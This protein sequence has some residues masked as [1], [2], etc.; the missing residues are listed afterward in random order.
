MTVSI[1][2]NHTWIN[3]REW[4]N[5]CWLHL[6]LPS[7]SIQSSLTSCRSRIVF[8]EVVEIESVLSIFDSWFEIMAKNLS[9]FQK[10][11][12]ISES[13]SVPILHSLNSL[14]ISEI[15]VG[16]R[17]FW[18]I[19]EILSAFQKSLWTPENLGVLQK[20]WCI[21][22]IFVVFQKFLMNLRNSKLCSMGLSSSPF[23]TT[24]ISWLLI[25]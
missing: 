4:T 19:L 18:R 13:L 25:Q 6:W 3:F 8:K 10:Y 22:K 23:F 7:Q 14:C 9:A 20:F 12:W 16:Y 5:G 11:W 17:K 24:P 15:F 21:L 1:Y 2:E